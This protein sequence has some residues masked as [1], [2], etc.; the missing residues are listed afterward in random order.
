MDG[1]EVIT[2]ALPKHPLLSTGKSP[3]P[4]TIPCSRKTLPKIHTPDLKTG[5]K[6]R[7]V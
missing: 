1:T 2:E 5:V 7:I 4:L 6:A 3:R